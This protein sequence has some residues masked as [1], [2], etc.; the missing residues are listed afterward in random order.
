MTKYELNVNIIPGTTRQH[1]VVLFN[2]NIILLLLLESFVNYSLKFSRQKCCSSTESSPS[3]LVYDHV[4]VSL[5]FPI[6]YATGT[7]LNK[8]CMVSAN[9]SS[10]RL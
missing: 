6:C 10:W 8:F 1:H 3:S 2:K 5:F 4:C 9:D 7:L